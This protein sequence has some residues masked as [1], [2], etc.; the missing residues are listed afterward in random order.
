MTDEDEKRRK[1][2]ERLERVKGLLEAKKKKE[3]EEKDYV[4]K[5]EK[6]EK[7]SGDVRGIGANPSFLA[8]RGNNNKK[9]RS[10]EERF[11]GGERKGDDS[12]AAGLRVGE[13]GGNGAMSINEEEG[14]QKNDDIDPLDAFMT[15]EIHPEIAEKE[16]A[17]RKR[18]ER[19]REERANMDEG[20]QR[21][22]LKALVNDSDDD[23][24]DGN[25]ENNSSKPNEIIY[26]PTN[27][28]KLFVGASGENVKRMQK[29][30]NCR[31]QIRKK[32]KAMYEG[33]SGQKVVL[34]NGDE[35]DENEKDDAKTCVELY[36]DNEAVR[37]FKLLLEDLF[38]R[39][40]KMKTESRKQ[41]RDRQKEKR[42]R[43]KRLFHLRHAA[44]YERLG[45]PL[46]A[47][48][49]EIEKAY[50]KLML[51]LHPDK[52]RSKPTDEREKIQ[53]QYDDMRASYDKLLAVDEENIQETKVLGKKLHEDELESLVPEEEIR[54][55]E[56]KRKIE[57]AKA[58]VLS[59]TAA[60]KTRFTTTS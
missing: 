24:D 28:V 25:N 51:A 36:G 44:D 32:A 54:M 4:K 16:R 13:N 52:H 41:D 2:K 1:Q 20:K 45:V 18:V 26:I 55:D 48:C 38:A 12:V 14:E 60:T 3:M 56:L 9:K 53:R 6:S 40:K 39:A 7:K 22:M 23:D 29:S 27:K 50:R 35:S 42:M 5:S 15:K 31:A 21:K 59:S 58:N 19:E 46:G 34:I 11:G 37:T 8:P 47:P 17:E 33:F 30:S 57:E 43:E 49:K 10:F